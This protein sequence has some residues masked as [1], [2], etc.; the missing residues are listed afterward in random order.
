MK[1]IL[2][3]ICTLLWPA[4]LLADAQSDHARRIAALSDTFAMT[5]PERPLYPALTDPLPAPL[6]RVHVMVE[7]CTL[8]QVEL[9]ENQFSGAYSGAS[10]RADLSLVSIIP[11]VDGTQ[12]QVVLDYVNADGTLQSSLFYLESE[13]PAGVTIYAD[14]PETAGPQDILNAPSLETRETLN[15]QYSNALHPEVG[16]VDSL[17]SELLAYQSE[18]CSLE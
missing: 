4:P 1:I 3:T 8:T 5:A 14:L 18:Y 16:Q 10:L 12:D 11:I 13:Q 17:V 6:R 2:T 7:G 9:W 15:W